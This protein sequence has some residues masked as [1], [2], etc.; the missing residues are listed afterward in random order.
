MQGHVKQLQHSIGFPRNRWL[1]LVAAVY[2]LSIGN[3]AVADITLEDVDED[4]A[5]SME[6]E[7]YKE[8]A[9]A[10]QYGVYLAEQQYGENDSRLISYLTRLASA[11]ESMGEYETALGTYGRAVKLIEQHEG[12]FTLNLVEVLAGLGRLFHNAGQYEQAV[13]AYQEAIHISRRNEGLYNLGQID[14]LDDL[15]DSYVA[16]GELPDADREQR[17]ALLSHQKTYGNSDPRVA[18]GYEKLAEW[19]QR[20]EQ[21]P[22]QRT[23]LRQA[24]QVLETAKGPDDA[25]L[26]PVLRALAES[27]RLEG[28]KHKEAEHALERAVSIIENRDDIDFAE[29][30]ATLIELGDYYI[31]NDNARKADAFY[32]MAWEQLSAVPEG[33]EAVLGRP[34]QLRYEPPLAPEFAFGTNPMDGP[35]YVDLRYTVTDEGRVEDV[36]VLETNVSGQLT[37]EVSQALRASRYRPRYVDGVP[38]STTGL[39]LRQTYSRLE[40]ENSQ[41]ARSP[42]E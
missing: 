39:R 18:A 33:R 10:A 38:A 40:N 15:T 11:Q 28:V 41:V 6:S 8:A 4:Y 37:R 2:S 5:V 29:H 14:L 26:V 32:R 23:Y 35:P 7:D 9:Q 34:R 31:V 21:Y 22:V 42:S 27:Y 1:P 13:S 12:P 16:M 19:Y 30:S 25:E 36:E 20:I 17:Y 24:M 3:S